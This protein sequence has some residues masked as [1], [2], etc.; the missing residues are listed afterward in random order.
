MTQCRPVV[1]TCSVESASKR[2]RLVLLTV[3][4]LHPTKTTV[5]NL[6]VKCP[7]EGRGC[8][9]QG[10]LGGAARHTDENCDYQIV[11]CDNEGCVVKMERGQLHGGMIISTMHAPREST[12]VPTA[13][14]K[15]HISK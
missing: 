13:A 3:N 14:K 4:S 1:G 11:E 8:Q 9:W 7:N 5:H 2:Q 12:S 6:K 10:D 15:A